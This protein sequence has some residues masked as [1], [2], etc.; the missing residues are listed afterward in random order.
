M[1]LTNPAK[2]APCVQQQSDTFRGDNVVLRTAMP[3]KVSP[4]WPAAA[5]FIRLILFLFIYLESSDS[6]EC[7]LS[8]N[9]KNVVHV[10]LPWEVNVQTGRW[11]K[12][13]CRLVS[14]KVLGKDNNTFPVSSSN[15]RFKRLDRSDPYLDV[16]SP[17]VTR[18]DDNTILYRK[19]NA[20]SDDDGPYACAVDVE[21]VKYPGCITTVR[22]RTKKTD[23]TMGKARASMRQ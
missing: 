10:D 17:L 13:Y 22:I 9:V 5:S 11:V 1:H 6:K 7:H 16:S 4:G 14:R 18:M 8:R 23:K 12:I 15:L 20:S 21:G 2:F 3:R 19:P